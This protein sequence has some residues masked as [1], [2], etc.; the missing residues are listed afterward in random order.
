MQGQLKGMGGTGLIAEHANILLPSLDDITMINAAR[1]AQGHSRLTKEEEDV[2][3]DS[4]ALRNN[5][6]PHVKQK[7]I[8]RR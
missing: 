1:E 5:I 3:R 6:S 8:T 4:I 2:I 7:K